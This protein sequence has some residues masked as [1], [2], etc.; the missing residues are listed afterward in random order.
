MKELG[1]VKS[2]LNNNMVLISSS[3][4]L[5]IDEQIT[6]F[7]LV[8]DDRLPDIG[9]A[10]QVLIPK[11][12]LLIV[13]KQSK[14]IYLAERYREY[15]ERRRKVTEP[16]PMAKALSA[17]SFQLGGQTREV[18]EKVPGPWSAELDKEES[19][20]ISFSKVVTIGDFVG[21]K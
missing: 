3:E 10:K 16:S 12:E 14:D 1:K 8:K 6:V 5:E 18:I 9:G 19:L 11:G 21:R 15:S 7:T 2:I 13:C 4:G 20:E 17:V